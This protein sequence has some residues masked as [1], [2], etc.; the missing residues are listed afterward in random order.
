MKRKKY[1]NE[2][3]EWEKEHNNSLRLSWA[4]YGSFCEE[5]AEEN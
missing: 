1:I 2:W 4:I 3:F 5:N